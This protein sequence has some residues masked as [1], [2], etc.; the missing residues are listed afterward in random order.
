MTFMNRPALATAVL[1]SAALATAG[2]SGGG[3]APSGSAASASSAPAGTQ[4]YASMLDLYSAV[5]SSG[6]TCSDVTIEPTTTAKAE[7]SCD[8]G[9]GKTLVLQTWRDGASRDAGVKTAVTALAAKNTPYSVLEGV[10]AT[11]LWSIT[12]SGDSNVATQISHK[13]GGKVTS[14]TGRG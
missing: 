12:A 8:L 6:T 10:G 13:L 2:C 4:P 7:A 11:G 5:L 3:Q 14:S 9:G 1:L